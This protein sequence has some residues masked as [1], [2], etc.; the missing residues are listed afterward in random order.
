[1]I[2]VIASISFKSEKLHELKEIYQVF[3]PK[4]EDEPGCILYSPTADFSTEIPT[5][6]TDNSIITVIEKWESLAAFE[7]HLVAPHVQQFRE[8]IKG[9]VDKVTIKVLQE[10]I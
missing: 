5:Q 8:D 1:M 3:A 6:V 9:I 4:V 10:L 7:A 2:H